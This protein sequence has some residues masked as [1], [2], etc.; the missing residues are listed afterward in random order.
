MA[1]SEEDLLWG[2]DVS[3]WMMITFI[4][5]SC[6]SYSSAAAAPPVSVSAESHYSNHSAAVVAGWLS[7][8]LILCA[9]KGISSVRDDFPLLPF[10]YHPNKKFV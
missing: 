6:P 8:F 4:G 5:G 7:N 10:C 9:F 3:L 2:L 1:E